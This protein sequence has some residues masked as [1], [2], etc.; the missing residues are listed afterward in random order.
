MARVLTA[1][2]APQPGGLSLQRTRTN[3]CVPPK[4]LLQQPRDVLVQFQD[5]DDAVVLRGPCGGGG[6]G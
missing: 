5:H 2:C 6:C 4:A 3:L 1:L